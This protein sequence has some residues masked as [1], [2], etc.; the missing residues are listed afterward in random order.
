[1]AGPAYDHNLC[2]V[3]HEGRTTPIVVNILDVVS[4]VTILVQTLPSS[5]LSSV[6]ADLAELVGHSYHHDFNFSIPRNTFTEDPGAL[7]SSARQAS[8][9][10][11][12]D[13]P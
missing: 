13:P 2:G 12:R 10:T 7:L 5:S 4:S 1:M 8:F 3:S 11:V 9:M 6:L